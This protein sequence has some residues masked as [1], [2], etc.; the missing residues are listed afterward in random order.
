MHRALFLFLSSQQSQ[1]QIPTMEPFVGIGVDPGF[2]A[3]TMHQQNSNYWPF[4]QHLQRRWILTWGRGKG[5]CRTPVSTN[6][7]GTQICDSI[8]LIEHLVV[9]IH[10][11]LTLIHI[12]GKTV[13]TEQC[14]IQQDLTHPST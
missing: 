9:N 2:N 5:G 11:H 13:I 8:H 7:A 6:L 1:F 10:Y 4:Q 12:A 3:T 14:S